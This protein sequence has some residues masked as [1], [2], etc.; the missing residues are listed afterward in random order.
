MLHRLVS[1]T[2]LTEK[3][4][5]VCPD[6]DARCPHERTEPNRPTHVVGELEKGCAKCPQPTV[7]GDPVDDGSHG[8]FTDPEPDV[9]SR[10]VRR[11]VILG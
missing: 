1:G 5:V 8:V 7:D 9:A 3:H 10:R 11:R 6:P 4:R 2:I